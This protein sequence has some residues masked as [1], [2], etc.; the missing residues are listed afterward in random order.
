MLDIVSLSKLPVSVGATLTLESVETPPDSVAPTAAS[1]EDSGFLTP[2][3][4][5]SGLGVL[6]LG[7]PVVG[8]KV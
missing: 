6:L 5:T 3:S 2:K 1:V 4:S 7:R 8:I